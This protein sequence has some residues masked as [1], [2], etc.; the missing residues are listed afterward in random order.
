MNERGGTK[1]SHRIDPHIDRERE[2]VQTDLLFIGSATAYAEIERPQ[3]PKQLSNATGD[4]IVTDGRMSVV[5]LANS[6]S[7]EDTSVPPS[8]T[9][10][11]SE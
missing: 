3:A 8:L 11:P 9:T 5:E 7:P 1:W 4:V 6:S 2:W 10:R